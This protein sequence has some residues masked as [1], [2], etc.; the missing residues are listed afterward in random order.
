MGRCQRAGARPGGGR[1]EKFFA[2]TPIVT[3]GAIVVIPTVDIGG[4]ITVTPTAVIVS[5]SPFSTQITLQQVHF[6]SMWVND[7]WYTTHKAATSERISYQ[8]PTQA[9][10]MAVG[11]RNEPC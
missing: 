5:P 9:A 4:N 1:D 7:L 11:V 3:G 8:N 10:S 6:V 2:P